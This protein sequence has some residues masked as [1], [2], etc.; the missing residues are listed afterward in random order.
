MLAL[1]ACDAVLRFDHVDPSDAAPLYLDCSTQKPPTFFCADFTDSGYY[2]GG[3]KRPL[4]GVS[5]NT[6][7]MLRDP[8][9]SSPSA[10]WI[11]SSAQPTGDYGIDVIDPTTT[12][13]KLHATFAFALPT[14]SSQDAKLFRIGLEQVPYDTCFAN[15]F[16]HTTGLASPYLGIESHCGPDPLNTGA[17]YSYTDVIALPL[18]ELVAVDFTFDVTAAMATVTV[19]GHEKPLMMRYTSTIGGQPRVVFGM[20]GTGGTGPVVGYDDVVVTA[21]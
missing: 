2:T 10:L 16:I 6:A 3:L 15:L 17:D 20:L 11:E 7:P 12:A 19:A 4:P 13:T 14:V 18:G 1:C 8:Y 9:T 21:E 5:G